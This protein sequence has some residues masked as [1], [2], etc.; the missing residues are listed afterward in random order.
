MFFGHHQGLQLSLYVCFLVSWGFF[1]FLIRDLEP[2][3][4]LVATSFVWH[5]SEHVRLLLFNGRA[6]WQS[7]NPTA[8]YNMETNTHRQID[9][10]LNARNKNSLTPS[11]TVDCS[12][13]PQHHPEKSWRA[14]EANYTEVI[15]W[16]G[17]MNFVQSLS[18]GSRNTIVDFC[19]IHSGSRSIF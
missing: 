11:V 13:D 2:I 6:H 17:V 18:H 14:K 3:H 8:S 7:L 10:A 16:S 19:R 1:F 4:L 9:V 15:Q 5:F 12:R